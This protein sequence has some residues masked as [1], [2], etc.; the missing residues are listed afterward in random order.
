MDKIKILYYGLSPNLGG[1]ETYLKKIFDNIDRNEFEICFL[2][3]LHKVCFEDYFKSKGGRFYTISTSRKNIFQHIIELNKLLSEKKFD[4]IHVNL[5]TL[6]SAELIYVSLRY[7]YRVIVHSRSSAKTGSLLSFLLHSINR[8]FLKNAGI[9]RIAVS[10]NAG[11]WMFGKKTKFEVYPNGIEISKYLFNSDKRILIRDYYHIKEDD[12]LIGCV[13]RLY[14]PKNQQ[15]LIELMS[16]LLSVNPNYKLIFIGDGSDKEFLLS[17]VE[18]LELEDKVIFAGSKID[19]SD[20]YSAFDIFAL[21]SF[22]EGFSNVALEAQTAGLPTI[23]S[24]GIP[25]EAIICSNAVRIA[26]EKDE[27]INCITNISLIKNRIEVKD[28]IEKAGFGI[29]EEINR[30]ELFYRRCVNE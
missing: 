8:F 2:K 7:N 28:I 14:Y 13:G 17:V 25:D 26:L 15:F 11:K 29:D 20:Y 3:S 5:N 30:L 19:V 10:E 22:F 12:I 6:S 16:G 23:L 4:I 1:I 21:P 9:E 27:W 18:K 24:K